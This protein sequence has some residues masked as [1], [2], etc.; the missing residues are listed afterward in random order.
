MSSEAHVGHLENNILSGVFCLTQVLYVTLDRVLSSVKAFEARWHRQ[1]SEI[2]LTFQDDTLDQSC[3]RINA[4]F[5]AYHSIINALLQIRSSSSDIH[6][7]LC[8]FHKKFARDPVRLKQVEDFYRTYHPEKALWWY[9]ADSFVFRDLNR[10]LRTHN[11]ELLYLFRFFIQDIQKQ[12]SD[13]QWPETIHVYRAQL[14]AKDELHTLADLIGENICFQSFLSTSM[15]REKAVFFFGGSN[16]KEQLHIGYENIIFDI[17]ANPRNN[18]N[19]RRPFSEIAQFSQFGNAEEEI[20]FMLG[21]VFHIDDVCHDEGFWT[22][23]M[24]LWNYQDHDWNNVSFTL[25]LS[26][27]EEIDLDPTNLLQFCSAL[28]NAGHVQLAEK[29]VKNHLHQL[30]LLNVDNKRL[31]HI[32]ECYQKLGHCALFR[33]DYSLAIKSFEKAL[34]LFASGSLHNHLITAATHLSM[35]NALSSVDDDEKAYTSYKIALSIYKQYY[36]EESP[37]IQACYTSIKAHS[38]EDQA[39]RILNRLGHFERPNEYLCEAIE[40]NN[41]VDL[42]SYPALYQ[43]WTEIQNLTSALVTETSSTKMRKRSVVKNIPPRLLNISTIGSFATRFI[44][45]IIVYTCP[46]CRQR[47]WIY[48]IFGMFKGSPCFLCLRRVLLFG[49][50]TVRH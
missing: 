43:E 22:V 13:H 42:A 12:L 16:S 3:T 21:A 14:I 38:A 36:D 20:L 30:T 33:R 11:I 45:P 18:T 23:K 15:S 1:Y 27:G 47:V 10:A 29:F 34:S 49:P 19:G 4:D 44:C 35:G 5:V 17:D 7:L 39:K 37:Q 31:V 6:D 50:G 26:L 24:T 2:I 48:K 46:C 32:G 25:Q 28:L 41:E 40:I 9:T 8:E